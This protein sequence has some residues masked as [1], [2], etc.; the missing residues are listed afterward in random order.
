ME[1]LD[2]LPGV[3]HPLSARDA[4]VVAAMREQAAAFKGAV[5]GPAG[6]E[7][8][9]AIMNSVA[10]PEGVGFETASVGGIRGVWC[11][12]ARPCANVAVLFLHGGGYVMGSARAYANFAGHF[13]QRLQA[14]VFVADYRL[15]PEHPF[16]AA[17][18]DA[19]ATYRGLLD[20]GAT[21]V[22]VIGDSA[23]GGLSL[24]L[25]SLLGA[26]AA[27]ASIRP[28]A[29]VVMSPW[30]DLSNRGASIVAK[31]DEELYLSKDMIDACA[32]MALGGPAA[33]HSQA[34]AL[35]APLQ[36]L[37]PLQI[38]RSCSTTRCATSSARSGPRPMSAC[39]CGKACR[40]C[41]RT[42]RE[43]CRLRIRRSRR[44][45]PS[46]PATCGRRRPARFSPCC[47]APRRCR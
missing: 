13:A 5:F 25:L 12:P 35:N 2:T 14:A 34:S 45:L 8:Y 26:R 20:A 19:F 15:A 24:S 6:R 4:G 38:Q 37:P 43:S 23:G 28:A 18:D 17:L 40:T 42:A 21:K 9:D 36:G 30:T 32:A 7:P 44:W 41:S 47:A 31:A 46:S 33:S 16:P 39:T 3:H 27:D 1:S 22:V 11:R 29:A 10:V